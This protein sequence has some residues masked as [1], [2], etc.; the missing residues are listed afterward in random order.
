MFQLEIDTGGADEES[1][2]SDSESNDV[3][4]LMD[5]LFG[6]FCEC[7]EL[8]PDPIESEEEE[9]HNWVFSADQVV[10]DGA[11]VDDSEWNGVLAPTSSIGYSNGDN[12][13]ARTALQI[14]TGGADE[15]SDSSDSESNDVLDLMDIL[16]GVFCECAELNPDPI[17]SEE[18]EEHNWVFSADQVVTDGAEV[19]DSEWNGVL[20]PTS[21]IGYSNGDNDLARTALQIDTG[22]ADEESDSS[23]SESND[24]LDLMDILFG[25]FCECAELNPDPIE[26]EEE[27]EHNWVFSADQ[28]VTDGAEVDDSEWNGILA[29]TSSIGYS[30]GDND[31]ARTA[32][33]VLSQNQGIVA[34]W[35]C[36]F[37]NLA[38]DEK[39]AGS[40]R[41]TTWKP[42]FDVEKE[43]QK[44]KEETSSLSKSLNVF[45]CNIMTN[46]T[47]LQ[48]ADIHVLQNHKFKILATP[49]VSV[50]PAKEE[51]TEASNN[52][53]DSSE[54]KKRNEDTTAAPRR[55]TRFED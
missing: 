51:V 28:V 20:A 46:Y 24:V 37:H 14:D 23:D 5:I 38:N 4:D 41:Q 18:E 47:R 32:L 9:E 43:K 40:Y 36:P 44:A 2:S 30:N 11:E 35:H 34:H 12:D 55:R 21:S 53:E 26:S 48:S 7:A 3:L 45:R 33:Q 39:V 16:F 31:L 29:P 1:D 50:K 42:K 25:V 27:E 17:E 15:E 19:D 49:K 54:E 10:T 22:G 52:G 8:N 13:L 6:V